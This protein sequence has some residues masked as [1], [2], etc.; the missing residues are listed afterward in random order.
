MK[1][2]LNL[3]LYFIKKDLRAKYAG[4]MLGV[5]WTFLMPLSQ[6]LLFWFVFSK[7]MKARPYANTQ[8]PYIY[9]LL[10]SYFCWLAFLEGSMR[11]ANSVVENSEIVKK[12]SFPKIILPFT[13]TISGYVP[14]ILGFVLFIFVYLIKI[15]FSPVIILVVPVLIL[16][17]IFSLGIGM[18]LSALL[19]YIRD[20]G[21]ILGQLLQ[22]MFFLSPIMYNMDAIPEKLKIIFYLNPMTYFVCSYQKIILLGE[23][24]SPY[25]FGIM[26]VIS[27]GS[28][29]Y[30][31]YVFH[32]LQEG[33]SDVL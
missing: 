18:I 4:S 9:F 33:F 29:I 11:A 32:K 12:I 19:P 21:Q 23:V 28:F 16:Q 14:N 26:T 7:I 15:F 1:N 22:G 3:L 17:V 27:L 25:Y 10:S 8:V 13:A 24:P 5:I 30:G 6:I 2:K 31:S 20:L